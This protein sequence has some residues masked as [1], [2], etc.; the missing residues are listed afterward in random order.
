AS[1]WL[2]RRGD[3]PEAVYVTDE[4]GGAGIDSRSAYFVRSTVVTNPVPGNRTHVFRDRADMAEHA[5]AFRG[6]R[7]A[8]AVRPFRGPGERGARTVPPPAHRG[9]SGHPVA[10]VAGVRHPG[11]PDLADALPAQRAGGDVQDQPLRP[12]LWAGGRRLRRRR[13]RRHL[14]L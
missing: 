1:L 9:P 3:R 6:R 14:L 2:A 13:P 5:R 8:G 7:L 4:A 11:R 12:R 10:A